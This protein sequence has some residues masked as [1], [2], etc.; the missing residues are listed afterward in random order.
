LWPLIILPEVTIN[1]GSRRGHFIT[2]SAGAS[3]DE[4]P[5]VRVRALIGNRRQSSSFDSSVLKIAA[6][7][8]DRI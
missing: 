4:I 3:S 5:M 2:S 1:N 8:N 7:H 6:P